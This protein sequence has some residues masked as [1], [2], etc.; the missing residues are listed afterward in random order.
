MRIEAIEIDLIDV[1]RG[2][3]IADPE[4]EQTLADDM[5]RF[6]Q[7]D[8]IEVVEAGDR[9]RLVDG[10][11]RVGACRLRGELFVTAKIKSAAEAANEADLTLREIA[12]NMMRR[13]LSVLDK[14]FDV[15]RWREVYEQTQGAVKPGRKAIRGKLAPNSEEA[16]DHAS[17]LF[18]SSFSEAAQ[19]ALDLNKDAVKRALRIAR[20]AQDV[21]ERISLFPIANNQSELLALS[22][23]TPDRQRQ[24][25]E[26]LTSGKARSVA[27]ALATIDGTEPVAKP[28]AWERLSDQ[29][30]KLGEPAQRRF[31][32][33]NWALIEALIA[34]RKAA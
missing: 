16:L 12:A 19:A 26:L 25:A 8:P 32:D 13:G 11:H 9:F 34:E 21:R 20:M 18:A 7:T 23:E 22:A 28:A 29:F 27:D 31:I 4:W 17:E 3:R 33:E 2:R 30:H 1:N 6:G 5:V 15:A 10:L 14:A 24:V